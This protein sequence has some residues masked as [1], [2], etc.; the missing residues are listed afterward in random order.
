VIRWEPCWEPHGRTASRY[1][2]LTRTADENATEVADR[3]ER[4]RTPGHRTT[5]Q[6]ACQPSL[7]PSSSQ[8]LAH[9]GRVV[10]H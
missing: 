3:C 5:D 4:V 6:K 1:S 2:G 9:I 7:T 10:E 8:A